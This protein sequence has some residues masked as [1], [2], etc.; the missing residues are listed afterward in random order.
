MSI[1]TSNTNSKKGIPKRFSKIARLGSDLF[2]ISDLAS[3]WEVRDPHVLRVTLKRYADKGLLF[4][5]HRG[6]YAIKP[7][8]QIDPFVLGQKV[9]RRFSYI[10]TET[11]LAEAGIVMQQT[12]VV[13][14][15]SP[16]SRKFSVASRRFVSGQLA[17]RFLFNEYGVIDKDGIKKATEERAVADM[18]YFNPRA[19]F[20]ADRSIDWKKVR[21]IQAHV[22]Y[23][24]TPKRY[25]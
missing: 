22:G 11:I 1:F 19:H 2:S 18:L 23:P 14:L 5:I 6:L 10:S 9:L 25:H 8:K 16:V 15:V 17:D 21:D 13:T 7:A 3:L 12:D 24:L 4:R 20:D